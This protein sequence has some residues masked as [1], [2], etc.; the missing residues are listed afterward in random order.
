MTLTPSKRPNLTPYQKRLVLEKVRLLTNH[1]KH[2][3]ASR[4]YNSIFPA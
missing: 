4:L 2:L 3:Q 1:G